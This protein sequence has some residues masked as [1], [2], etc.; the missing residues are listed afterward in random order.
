MGNCLKPMSRSTQSYSP[1]A[2]A[3]PARAS[4]SSSSSTSTQSF[5]GLQPREAMRSSE[6]ASSSAPRGANIRS[7]NQSTPAKA[8]AI[9]SIALIKQRFELLMA[10]N[11]APSDPEKV[12][13]LALMPTFVAAENARK[14]GLTLLESAANLRLFLRSGCP[15][16]GKRAIL[17]LPGYEKHS[18]AADVRCFNGRTSV[19]VIDPTT[20]KDYSSD[21]YRRSV[22]PG[23]SRSLPPNAVLTVIALDTQKALMGCRIFSLS[24]ASKLA[25]HR[26]ALAAIHER[27][28]SGALPITGNGNDASQV[29]QY[30]RVRVVDGAGVLPAAFYKH[31]QSS[32]T[33]EAWLKESS[34]DQAHV[35]VNSRNQTLLG[36]YQAHLTERYASPYSVRQLSDQGMLEQVFPPQELERLRKPVRSNTSIEHKRLVFLDRAID[37]LR[38]QPES[39]SRQLLARLRNFDISADNILSLNLVNQDFGPHPGTL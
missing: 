17:P 26:V 39:E 35:P 38:A 32:S 7:D 19:V 34:E 3:Y 16:E 20:P 24:A 11:W 4:F 36:R 10:G 29:A 14:P 21:N 15:P 31:S 23:L 6:A 1:D 12:F 18:V 5:E 37:H 27:N 25:D 33:L 13:D 8:E 2:G 30:G 22:L 28:L 9:Q